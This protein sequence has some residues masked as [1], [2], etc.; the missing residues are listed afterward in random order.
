MSMYYVYV[1]QSASDSGLY[2]GYSSN[3]KRRLFEHKSGAAT[4]T[5]YRGPWR[6]MYYEAYLEEADARGREEFLKSGAGRKHLQKQCRHH[7]A[8]SPSRSKA[9]V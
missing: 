3:L 7:F 9:S 2:I 5:A 8:K 1:L 4:S 6:L